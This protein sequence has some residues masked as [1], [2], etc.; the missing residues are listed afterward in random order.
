MAALVI[1]HIGGKACLMSFSVMVYGIAMNDKGQKS[2]YVIGTNDKQMMV[3]KCPQM[4]FNWH[5]NVLNIINNS[6]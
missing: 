3:L 2:R 1:P 6:V 4:R 5:C